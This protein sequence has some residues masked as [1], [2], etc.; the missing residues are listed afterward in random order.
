[1][2]FRR[3]RVRIELEESTLTLRLAAPAVSCPPP[4]AAPL[5]TTAFPQP[6][7]GVVSGAENEPKSIP[8]GNRH[9]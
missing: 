4:A 9:V 3:R 8:K 7:P 1:M 5:A 2:I 6:N